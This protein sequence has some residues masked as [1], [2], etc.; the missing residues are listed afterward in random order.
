[1][2]Q[3]RVLWAP[4]SFPVWPGARRK[5]HATL[6]LRLLDNGK[7]TFQQDDEGELAFLVPEY[8]KLPFD[9]NTGSLDMVGKN[10]VTMIILRS[11]F[12]EL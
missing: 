7:A 10:A 3:R 5:G 2:S 9:Y 4:S 6:G 11:D 12:Q 1:M 8:L